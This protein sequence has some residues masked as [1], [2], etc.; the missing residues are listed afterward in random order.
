MIVIGKEKYCDFATIQEGVNF[1]EQKPESETKRMIILSGVYEEYIEIRLSN[2]EMIGLGDVQIIGNRHARQLHDDGEELGTFRTATVF[3]E[4]ENI[5]V[6]NLTIINQAGQGD[7]IGQ[8]IALFAYCH[9][10]EFYNCR[11]EGHQDTLCTGPLPDAQSDGTAFTTVQLKYNLTYCKQ[12]YKNCFISGTVDFIFG[13]AAADFEN[14]EINSRYRPKQGGF[15][16]AASTPKGQEQGYVFKRCFISAEPGVEKIF[17]GRPWR[18]YAQ[19]TFDHCYL[20]EHIL[21]EGWDDWGKKTNQQTVK[22]EEIQSI[23]VNQ[24]ARPSWVSVK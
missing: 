24:L 20:G 18:P 7:G 14:C 10:A 5:I 9:H 17:L 21:P 6:R 8:A 1:L 11:L 13:G 22:Y 4:G 23:N 16:T 3:L 19:T 15:I 2:F 12:L